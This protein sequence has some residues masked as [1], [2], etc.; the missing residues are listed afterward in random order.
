VLTTFRLLVSWSPS[1]LVRI[2]SICGPSSSQEPHY[3]PEQE[4]AQHD[5]AGEQDG[6]IVSQWHDRGWFGTL[7]HAESHRPRLGLLPF[8]VLAPGLPIVVRLRRGQ[9][10]QRPLPRGKHRPHDYSDEHKVTREPQ[11]NPAA[12][13]SGAAHKRFVTMPLPIAGEV[14]RMVLFG[15]CYGPAFGLGASSS[16][17]AAVI[18]GTLTPSASAASG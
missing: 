18:A 3:H 15:P 16:S 11:P 14:L 17:A 9:F 1:F 5:R 13:L 12:E 2:C 10:C 8:H 4:A 7:G 6:K